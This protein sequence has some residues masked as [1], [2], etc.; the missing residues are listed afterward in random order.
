MRRLAAEHGTSTSA[1][2][3]LFGGKQQLIEAV[4]E[5]GARSLGEALA[6]VE[7]SADA[8]ADLRACAY[9][10]RAWVQDHLDLYAVMFGGR[11]TVEGR[12]STVRPL[13]TPGMAALVQLIMRLHTEGRLVESDLLTVAT[14]MWAMIHGALELD[15]E[16]WRFLDTPER[17]EAFFAAHVSALERAWLQPLPP[18]AA[19]PDSAAV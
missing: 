9:A 5:A 18:A 10:Y 6:A 17:R 14:S 4:I 8:V 7:I 19:E 1:I 12:E 3:A 13:I 16:L 11:F 2:Y 15:R